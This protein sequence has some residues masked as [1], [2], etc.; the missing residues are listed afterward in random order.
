[1]LCESGIPDPSARALWKGAVSAAAR[2]RDPDGAYY[3]LKQRDEGAECV[4]CHTKLARNSASWCSAD[5]PMTFCI[6]CMMTHTAG[7]RESR[8]E[9][10]TNY[11]LLKTWGIDLRGFYYYVAMIMDGPSRLRSTTVHQV[12]WGRLAIEYLASQI[13][14]PCITTAQWAQLVARFGPVQK[15]FMEL[16]PPMMWLGSQSYAFELWTGQIS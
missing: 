15:S 9:L 8:F 7:V 5:K 16:L 1:V 11:L 13:P 12:H 4:E 14:T 10:F 6:T 3:S 2:T